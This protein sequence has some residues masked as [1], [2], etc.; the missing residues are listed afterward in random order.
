MRLCVCVCVGKG[1]C[2]RE[3]E[4]VY[5]AAKT[6]WVPV[7][8]RS[9]TQKSPIISVS[10]VKHDLQLKA[11]YA[12]S[13][14]C[15]LYT[16]ACAFGRKRKRERE[17]ESVCVCVFERETGIRRETGILFLYF[18]FVIFLFERETGIRSDFDVSFM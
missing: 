14:L 9:F 6:H 5:R 4:C 15:S 1:G 18:L 11:S 17:R 8:Y 7:L 10:Y 12:S 16:R 2:E 3:C 13:P